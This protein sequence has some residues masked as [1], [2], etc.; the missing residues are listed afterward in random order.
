[1]KISDL[2]KVAAYEKAIKKKYGYNAV[3]NPN[4]DWD[5]DKEKEYLRQQKN[6]NQRYLATTKTMIWL[7]LMVF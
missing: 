7:K 6:L 2:N 1:M 3:K 4:Q 5:D